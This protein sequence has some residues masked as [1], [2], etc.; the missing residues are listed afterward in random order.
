MIHIDFNDRPLA[1]DSIDVPKRLAA[2]PWRVSGIVIIAG[3]TLFGAST[4]RPSSAI[5]ATRS[6]SKGSIV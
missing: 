4:L 3:A 6:K 2:H 5:A 1:G